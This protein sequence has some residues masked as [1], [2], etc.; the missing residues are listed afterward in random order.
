MDL[1]QPTATLENTA[2]RENPPSPLKRLLPENPD[3]QSDQ[4]VQKHQKIALGKRSLTSNNPSNI[5]CQTLAE[6]QSATPTT[7][8]VEAD[9]FKSFLMSV[10]PYYPI[11]GEIPKEAEDH[12]NRGESLD[13]VSGLSSP[14]DEINDAMGYTELMAPRPDAYPVMSEVECMEITQKSD[15]IKTVRPNSNRYY[16]Q[17][18]RQEF[19]VK[20]DLL[21]GYQS[22]QLENIS[23]DEVENGTIEAEKDKD[24]CNHT[25]RN[26]TLIEN[27]SVD[28]SSIP[29]ASPP[30]N[31]TSS[32]IGKK[33]DHT[34]ARCLPA[35][36]GEVCMETDETGNSEYQPDMNTSLPVVR[37]KDSYFHDIKLEMELNQ[38][39]V[40]DCKPK[41][42]GDIKKEEEVPCENDTTSSQTK[43]NSGRYMY[44]F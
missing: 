2:E 38:L 36:C 14:E 9:V 29:I 42:E 27:N 17:I 26:D 15:V 19:K 10:L 43:S 34:Y 13:L 3:S 25:R 11:E 23:D 7:D 21:K 18:K 35:A 5:Q 6:N 22:Q 32:P 1:T 40:P 44:L 20:K 30:N 16:S 28:S 4:E 37:K 24:E 41:V 33:G 12:D 39:A 31:L 8:T